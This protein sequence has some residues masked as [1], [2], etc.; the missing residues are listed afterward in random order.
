MNGEKKYI[1]IPSNKS[2]FT[3]IDENK[4][5]IPPNLYVNFE[6]IHN[7]INSMHETTGELFYEEKIKLKEKSVLVNF[8]SVEEI[9]FNVTKE[10]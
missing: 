1:L 8:D 5:S 7:L 10:N 9:I 4:D 2:V 6:N 3:F